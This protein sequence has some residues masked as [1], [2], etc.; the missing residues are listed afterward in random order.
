M[1]NACYLVP[2]NGVTPA[3]G[4]TPFLL[5][6]LGLS[7]HRRIFYFYFSQGTRRIGKEG[8]HA[9][10]RTWRQVSFPDGT[11][12]YYCSE[13]YETCYQLPKEST[14]NFSWFEEPV[15]THPGWNLIENNGLRYYVNTKTQETSWRLP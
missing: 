1:I 7:C 10:G 4:V 15:A 2:A 12:Y 6:L 11:S 9:G 13:T 5:L 14:Q 3:T 8:Y